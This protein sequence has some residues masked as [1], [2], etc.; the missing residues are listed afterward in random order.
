MFHHF[1]DNK[2]YPN[3]PGSLDKHQLRKIIKFIGKDNIIEPLEFIEKLKNDKLNSE[4]CLTFDDALKCQFDIAQPILEE[5]KLKAFYF[6]QT[7]IF[8]KQKDYSET[9]RFFRNNFYKNLNNFYN[10]FFYILKNKTKRDFFKFF[11]KKKKLI[12]KKKKMYPFYSIKDI[13]FRLIRD[14]FLSEIEYKEIM[15]EMFK[16][17]K[18]NYKKNLN[19]IFLNKS[20][21]KKLSKKGNLIGLHSHSHTFNFDKLTFKQQLRDYK[22]NKQIIN[23]IIPGNIISACYPGGKLNS[24]SL[25]VLKKLNIKCCFVDTMRKNKFSLSKNSY[26]T[27][28]RED[29]TNIIK[30]IN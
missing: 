26:L 8:E 21:I 24:H 3:S 16:I 13:K 22:K 14:N 11:I 15:I 9:Y 2:N 19:N 6:I 12:L 29:S 20:H 1:H 18:F 17:K 4:I 10:D 7:S 23:K 28:P 5:F 25:K 27:V 30:L